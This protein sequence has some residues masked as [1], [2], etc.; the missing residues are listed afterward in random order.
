MKMS[1]YTTGELNDS[2]YVKNPLRSNALINFK[3]D[4]KDCLI[5]SMLAGFH[6]CDNDPN[7]VSTN[8]QFSIEFNIQGFVFTN[9][10]ESSDMHKFEKLNNLTSNIYESNFY[11]D[12]KKWK[13][14]LIPIENGKHASDRINDLAIYKN[15]YALIKKIN[16]CIGKDDNKYIWGRCLYSYTNHNVLKNHIQNCGQQEVTSIILSRVPY[17]FWENHFHKNPV[18]FRFI[19]AF[20]AEYKIGD[21]KVVGKKKQPKL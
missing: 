4:D 2:S 15:Q 20:E 6:P 14:K 13:H 3:N 5:W 11:K 7:R 8:R 21:D 16:E 10:F 1:F 12:D 19:A 18:L 9:G 17:I